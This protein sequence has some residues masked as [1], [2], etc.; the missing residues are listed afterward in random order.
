MSS[1]RSGG[2]ERVVSRLANYW[3]SQGHDVSIVTI[4]GLEADFYNLHP[5]VKRT[6]LALNAGG[7]VWAMPFRAAKR[8]FALRRT[9]SQSSP[10][11]ILSFLTTINIMTVIA[12]L[13][14]KRPL[15]LSERTNPR[16]QKISFL[17]RV[18]RRVFYPLSDGVVFVS[19][20]ARANSPGCPRRSVR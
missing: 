19:E 6:G 16:F 15:I 14:T 12:C 4:E 17:G 10:D 20:G 7:A 1:L 18:M 13:F 5:D 2:A 8:I 11:V 9:F 3:A